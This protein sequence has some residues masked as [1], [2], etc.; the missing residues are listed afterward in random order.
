MRGLRTAAISA[1]V[2]VVLLAV[3]LGSGVPFPTVP[4]RAL[5]L[6]GAPGTAPGA[7]PPALAGDEWQEFQHDISNSGLSGA[8]AVGSMFTWNATLPQYPDGP[9]SPFVGSPVVGQGNVYLPVGDTLVAYNADSGRPVWSTALTPTSTPAPAVVETPLLWDGLLFVAEDQGFGFPANC[10]GADCS[11]L[12]VLNATNGTIMQDFPTGT[13]WNGI[14][15]PGSPVPLEGGDFGGNNGF[16]IVDHMGYVYTYNWNGSALTAVGND[17]AVRQGGTRTTSTPSIADIPGLGWGAFFLDGRG[18]QRIDA[19]Q[20]G[21]GTAL[22]F[23]GGGYPAGP[24]LGGGV[25]VAWTSTNTGSVSIANF[26][27]NGGPYPVGFFGDDAGAGAASLL[28]ALN[29]TNH[30]PLANATLMTPAATTV[31]N[32]L[33]STPALVPINSTAV[34]L[35]ITDLNG[36]VSRYNFTFPANGTTDAT[37]WL[38]LSW[39][40]ATGD[41]FDGSAAVAGNTTYVGNSAGGL[42]ALNVSTGAT[43]WN[44][45]LSAPI[46]SN[47]AVGDRRLFVVSDPVGGGTNG[48]LTA[49]GPQGVNKLSLRPLAVPALVASG[50]TSMIEVNASWD[51]PRSEYGGPAAG[52]VVNFSAALG[53]FSTASVTAGANGFAFDNWTAPG[54]SP[55]GYNVTVRLMGSAPLNVSTLSAVRIGVQ[56]GSTG[57]GG[58]LPVTLV[59]SPPSSSLELGSSEILTIRAST[60]GNA[61]VAGDGVQL[62]LDGPGSLNTTAPTATNGSGET[63]VEFTAPGNLSQPEVTLINATATEGGYANSYA[64]AAVAMSPPPPGSRI[65]T[66]V[67]ISPPSSVLGPAGSESLTITVETS[68]GAPV[69]GADVAFVQDGLGSLSTVSPLPTNGAGQTMVT[70][71]APPSLATSS[72]TLLNATAGEGGYLTSNASAVVLLS[73]AS[74]SGLSPMSVS[75]SPSTSQLVAGSSEPL[76]IQVA[77]LSGAPLPNAIVTLTLTGLGSL[78]PSTPPATDSLGQTTVEFEAPSDLLTANSSL[79][80]ASASLVGYASAIAGATVSLLPS[81]S[82]GSSGTIRLNASATPDAVAVE[83]GS[84]TSIT[85]VVTNLSASPSVPFAGATVVV[86]ASSAGPGG[87]SSPVSVVTNPDGV[88]TFTFV[89]SKTTTGAVLAQFTITAA[90]AAAASAD[91]SI[92]VVSASATTATQSPSSLGSLD[93]GLIALVFLLAAGLLLLLVIGRRPR[94][95]PATPP[96]APPPTPAPS[97]VTVASP[98]VP[99]WREDPPKPSGSSK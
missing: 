57:G 73:V 35:V 17:R 99:P 79:V 55:V 81:S 14:A 91:V 27:S 48:N 67:T 21:N 12:Y 3:P 72:A 10:G 13:I 54:T 68:T 64:S 24:G 5:A 11:S 61:P 16:V 32:G 25:T 46:R 30:L 59:V 70:F 74:S 63:T 6:G 22:P 39:T 84:S 93:Y 43:A 19:V 89:A 65:P 34:G 71:T 87:F 76:T 66:R 33:W 41:S 9:D 75:I 88:A 31:D 50:G 44:T 56:P 58:A 78:A 62:T 83:A 37:G 60:T 26:S 90:H 4:P 28:V 45:T 77:S 92:S 49:F 42:W 85:I 98:P 82:A 1:F 2:V 8:P 23:L 7:P 38:N 96:P 40:F 69:E 20:L 95:P 53:T 52:A 18:N 80:L 36:S 94:D 15:A 86:S 97:V 29:L 47:F 51:T